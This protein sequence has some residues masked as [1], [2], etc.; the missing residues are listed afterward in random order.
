MS[1]IKP[2]YDRVVLR[3]LE[4]DERTAGGIIIPDTAKEKPQK[5]EIIAVGSGTKNESGNVVPLEVKV[6]DIVLFGKWSGSE[7]K[8]DGEELLVM[9][10]SDIIAIIE[11][12][13]SKK[14]AA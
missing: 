11:E 2:L 1:T 10:E 14:K 3:R 13:N 5:G 9:K 6:G 4:E 7:V 12:S 8:F